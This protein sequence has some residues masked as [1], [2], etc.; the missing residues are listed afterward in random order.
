MSSVTKSFSQIPV[1]TKFLTCFKDISGA[2]TAGAGAGADGYAAFILDAGEF[3]N[4]TSMATQD[5]VEAAAGFGPLGGGANVNQLTA[6]QLFKDMGR[7]ITVLDNA[8]DATHLALYRQ[9]QL[10]SGPTTEGVANDAAYS[11]NIYVR[12]WAA[13]GQNVR[14][15]RLG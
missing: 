3:L 2:E 10:V 8:D 1:Q 6:G 12:V 13:D 5:I 9:V 7:Q 11:A 14:V 4:V 15:A